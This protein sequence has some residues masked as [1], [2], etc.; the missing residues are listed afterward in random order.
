MISCSHCFMLFFET[1]VLQEIFETAISC[2]KCMA[3][4]RPSYAGRHCRDVLGQ[5]GF[6]QA[7]SKMLL[8]KVNYTIAALPRC[9]LSC[10]RVD[11]IRGG[12]CRDVHCVAA[13]PPI[14]RHCR[15][16]R[17]LKSKRHCR[18]GTAAMCTEKY[19]CSG[20]TRTSRT[21]FYTCATSPSDDE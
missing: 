20:I 1:N 11:Y 15:H 13:L 2:F 4:P 16:A 19:A 6:S 14:L 18:R 9:A 7:A 5:N 3:L 17:A 10:V 8:C 12:R 21:L